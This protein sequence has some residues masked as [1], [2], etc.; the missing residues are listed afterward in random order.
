MHQ[1]FLIILFVNGRMNL[2]CILVSW[3]NDTIGVCRA[4]ISAKFRV[5]R[6]GRAVSKFWAEYLHVLN[7]QRQLALVNN[8]LV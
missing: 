2:I 1:Y 8:F 6:L 7:A 3:N 5:L 4:P